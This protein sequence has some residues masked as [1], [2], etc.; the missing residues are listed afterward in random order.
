[1]R[2]NQLNENKFPW[3]RNIVW[4]LGGAAFSSKPGCSLWKESHIWQQAR[5]RQIR[6]PA[7]LAAL[8]YVDISQTRVCSPDKAKL[9]S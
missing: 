3:D 8:L 6:A 7:V 1:M 9:S 4:C 2:L 5:L